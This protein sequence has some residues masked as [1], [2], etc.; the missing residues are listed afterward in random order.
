[1]VV[2]R[3]AGSTSRSCDYCGNSGK[4]FAQP[5]SGSDR[6]ICPNCAMKACEM[7]GVCPKNDSLIDR[8]MTMFSNI[9]KRLLDSKTKTLIKA[10]FLSSDLKLTVGGEEALLA[11]LLSQNMDDLVKQAEEKIAEEKDEKKQ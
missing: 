8:T 11:S 2:T 10:G 1:M 4:V 3:C 7:M 9:A 5:H 6:D